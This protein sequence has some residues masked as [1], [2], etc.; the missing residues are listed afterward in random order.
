MNDEQTF[1]PVPTPGHAP[2]WW[3][4]DSCAGWRA[5][6]LQKVEET[7]CA[8]S[9]QPAAGSARSLAEASGSFGGLTPP[10]NV[11]VAQDGSIYLLDLEAAQLKRFDPCTCLFNPVPCI[12]G[13]GVGA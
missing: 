3:L 7:A 10:L 2:R 8:L 4:L 5:A 12:A 9:L 11:A 6:S 13:L 1:L